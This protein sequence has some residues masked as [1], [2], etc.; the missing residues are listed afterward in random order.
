LNTIFVTGGAG[1]VGSHCAKAFSRAGWNVVTFDDLSRG[2]R[3]MVRYGPLIKGDLR[4]R[5]ALDAA[6]GEVR[7]DV[8]A[9]FAA[10]A[11]VNESFERPGDYYAVNALGS[12]NLLEAMRAVGVDKLI[13]SSTCA[14]YGVP[15]T[16]PIR[17]DAPQRP[18]NPYGWSKLFVERMLI[19]HA[20]AYGLRYVSLRYF[21]AAGADPE[22]ELG[23][24]HEPESHVIP[25][26]ARALLRHDHAFVINGTDFATPDGTAVRDYVH[27]ADLGRA[28]AIA[29]E[30]LLSGG[31]SDVLNLGTGIGVSVAEIADAVERA[32]GRALLRK[33]GPRRPG[34]PPVLVAAG[35]RAREVLGWTPQQSSIEEIIGSAWRWHCAEANRMR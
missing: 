29:A 14:T 28:H 24:R 10:L 31:G 30:Y 4:D 22:G 1:Y 15:D 12:L 13:F 21:N 18:I 7:P 35:D 8:V 11:Y 2:W 25:L 33:A 19:D 20:A 34:D 6:L 23:E 27:V 9:H 32:S 16:V 17:E 5:A 3:D 26:A